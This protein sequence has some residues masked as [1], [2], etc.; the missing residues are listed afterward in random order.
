LIH[1]HELGLFEG[2]CE[3]LDQVLDRIVPHGTFGDVRGTAEWAQVRSAARE[4]Y[5]A[6]AESEEEAADR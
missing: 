6:L 3:R 1:Q 2:L 5:R 4:L